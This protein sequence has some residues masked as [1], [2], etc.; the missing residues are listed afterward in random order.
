M[1]GLV[2]LLLMGVLVWRWR[3]WRAS[4]VQKPAPATPPKTIAM[5]ACQHCG[6]HVPVTDAIHGSQGS[7]C[8]VDHRAQRE[9]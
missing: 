8:C 4:A 9:P 3:S 7:Y 6:L 1:R 5:L 2:L